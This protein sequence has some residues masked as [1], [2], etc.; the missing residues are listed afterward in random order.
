MTTVGWAASVGGVLLI[1]SS[2][3]SNPSPTRNTAERVHELQCRMSAQRYCAA[4]QGEEADQYALNECI[5]KRA[6]DC[7][8]GQTPAEQRERYAPEP[9]ASP[10]PAG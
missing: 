8:M 5:G 2:G 3:C 1:L 6:W 10:E 4:Q 9:V 7:I